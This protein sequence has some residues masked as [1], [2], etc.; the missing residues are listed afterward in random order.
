M[1]GFDSG[2]PVPMTK[3]PVPD[4]SGDLGKSPPKGTQESTVRSTPS[5]IRI[6]S[7]E[8]PLDP[9][10]Q[11]R[12]N[13]G[14]SSLAPVMIPGSQDGSSAGDFE[15]SPS[16]QPRTRQIIDVDLSYERSSG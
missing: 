10:R 3:R 6:I 15:V 8:L 5:P 11:R 16:Q 14:E 4:D 1:P 12:E 2:C 13:S 7:D 9:R